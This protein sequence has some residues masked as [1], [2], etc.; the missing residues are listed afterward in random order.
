MDLLV[1]SYTTGTTSPGAV[2]AH[3]DLASGALT[4]SGAVA[5]DDPSWVTL[6]DG[7]V[8]AVGEHAGGTVSSAR[9]DGSDVVTLEGAGDDPCHLLVHDGHVVVAGYSSG[10]VAVFALG[11][12]GALTE[13]THLLQHSGSGP[14]A[15]RQD[16]PH[17]HQVQASPTAGTCW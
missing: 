2:R 4:A 6:H 10:T 15:D 1:G 8:Y 17:V 3:L 12:D 5:F 11:A 7:S 13:R 16:A 14:D 9:L